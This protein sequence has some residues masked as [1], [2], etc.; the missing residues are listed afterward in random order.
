MQP[1]SGT[2]AGRLD[3]H[4]IDSTLLRGNPLGDPH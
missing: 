1:W 3:E 4:V 2:L